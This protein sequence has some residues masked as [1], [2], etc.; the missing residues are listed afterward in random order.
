M[1]EFIFSNFTNSLLE[2][3]H[4]KTAGVTML[5]PAILLFIQLCL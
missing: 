2:F 4:F 5:E 1:A 3:P